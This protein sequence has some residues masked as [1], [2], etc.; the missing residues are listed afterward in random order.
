MP[1]YAIVNIDDP[2]RQLLPDWQFEPDVVYPATYDFKRG[3]GGSK[4]PGIPWDVDWVKSYR[5]LNPGNEEAA[6]RPGNFLLLGGEPK[7]DWDHPEDEPELPKFECLTTS[8]NILEVKQI[9]K[10]TAVEVNV[11][12]PDDPAPDP[13]VTNYKTDLR[14][15]KFTAIRID[16]LLF[17][18]FD[19]RDVYFY[20]RAP[21]PAWLPWDHVTLFP[22]PGYV[23]TRVNL[24]I[25]NLPGIEGELLDTLPVGTR[26]RVHEY[27]PSMGNV[28]GLT[29]YGYIALRYQPL[30]GSNGAYHTTT[31]SL[32]VPGP[33]RPQAPIPGDLPVFGGPPAHVFTNQDM[34]NSF[35]EAFGQVEY[36]QYMERTNL[37][38]LVNDRQAAYAGPVVSQLGLPESDWR[39]LQKAIL[40]RLE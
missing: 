23:T 32:G 36:W 9:L 4:W 22:E 25:R 11:F 31:W 26:V 19:G 34:I 12:G 35:Y 38:G 6:F 20:L 10:G 27:F 40:R 3:P 1:Q 5:D 16:G 2:P 7:I 18:I 28:W 37:T 21:G 29:P 17:N 39:K 8:G 15:S 24:N 30:P 14:V 13:A 33:L